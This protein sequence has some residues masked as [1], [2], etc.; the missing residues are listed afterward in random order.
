MSEILPEVLFLGIDKY[1]FF[2]LEK[3]G[4]GMK[5]FV[6]EV[7]GNTSQVDKLW[8]LLPVIY[9]VL[10]ALANPHPRYLIPASHFIV[11]QLQW[12]QG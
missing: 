9:A 8:S 10:L 6:G 7:T 12:S 11:L 1:P 5:Y 3:F 4:F 2:C